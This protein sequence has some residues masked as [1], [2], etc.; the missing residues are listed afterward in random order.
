MA[1]ELHLKGGDLEVL[2]HDA[3]FE[4][5][6]PMPDRRHNL[7]LR[8]ARRAEGDAELV[9][10]L[11]EGGLRRGGQRHGASDG[12]PPTAHERNNQKRK[13]T[14]RHPPMTITRKKLTRSQPRRAEHKQ[15]RCNANA[16]APP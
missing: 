5:G 3:L 14:D 1:R 4:G 16:R 9:D 11:D 12:G 6:D 15:R 8:V 10:E 7:R 2:L 13:T